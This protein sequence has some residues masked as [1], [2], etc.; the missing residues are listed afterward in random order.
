MLYSVTLTLLLA[1]FVS[2]ATASVPTATPTA[3]G[4]ASLAPT[5]GCLA[6]VLGYSRDSCDLTCSR[7]SRTCNAEY[8]DDIIT[9]QAFEDMVDE[10][11]YLRSD[12]SGT[13]AELCNMGTNVYNF[14]AA[15]A[16]FTYRMYM[17]PGGEAGFSP[18]QYCNYP[19]SL[20]GL[21]GD[22]STKYTYP[23]TQRFCPCVSGDCTP[24]IAPTFASAAPSVVPTAAPTGCYQWILGYSTESCTQ[25]C[26]NTEIGGTCSEEFLA[27]INSVAAFE[28]MV[29]EAFMLGQT[30]Q[31]GSAAAFCGG[32]VNPWLFAGAPAAFAY[33]TYVQVNGVATLVVSYYCNFND[34][35]SLPTSPTGTPAAITGDCDTRYYSPPSQ[36]FCPC[37]IPD[38]TLWETTHPNQ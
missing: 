2:Q 31:P 3:I 36:R 21:T 5:A 4:D 32:G 6:W 16:V 34:A 14:A 15:P 28:Q 18:A 38:C 11:H 23:P 27:N 17:H 22:C 37:A 30:T 10:A 20:S 33:Q 7:V 8:F 35:N 24:T 9:Q 25:T 26:Q 12:F 29:S 19:T 13:A 1:G